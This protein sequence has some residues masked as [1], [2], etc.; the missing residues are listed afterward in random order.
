MKITKLILKNF[1]SIKNAMDSN[2]ISIDF[3]ECKNS[4]CLF[5]GPNA[6]GK[7]SILSQLQPFATLGNLDT[8]NDQPLIL[9]NKEGYKELHIQKKNV[10]YI[11]KH[12][13]SPKNSGGHSVKSYIIKDG[14][15]LNPNGNVTSFKEI[16]KEELGIELDYL[17]LIRLGSNVKSLI[18][19]SD[20]ERKSFMSNILDEIGVYLSYYK[21]VGDKLKNIKEMISHTINKID[22]LG[23]E[24]ISTEKEYITTIENRLESNKIIE[25]DLRDKLSIVNYELSNIDN[26]EELRDIIKKCEKKI[27]KMKT[28]LETEVNLDK[29]DVD[30]YRDEI[31]KKIDKCNKNKNN[32][33]MLK[34]LMGNSINMLD[35]YKNQHHTFSMQYYNELEK[36]KEIDRLEDDLKSTRKKLRDYESALHDYEPK[37]T[38]QELEKFIID[39]KNIQLYLNKTYDFGNKPIRKV[40]SLIKDGKDVNKYINSHIIE[41]DDK[42]SDYDSL[43]LNKLIKM[44]SD[45]GKDIVSSCDKGCDAKRIYNEIVKIC[46][47]HN[48]EDKTKYDPTFYKDMEYSYQSIKYTIEQINKYSDFIKRIP[49]NKIVE[50]FSMNNIFTHIEKLEPIY[51]KEKINSLLSIAKEYDNY[52]MC[53]NKYESD[54]KNLSMFKS[55]SNLDNIKHEI[56][57]LEINI[58]N[59]ENEIKD[60]REQISDLETENKELSRDLE[61]EELILETIV[62][63]DE[64]VNLYSETSSKY[65][66]MKKCNDEIQDIT[67]KLHTIE[68]NIELN[69]STLSKETVKLAQYKELKK[70]LNKYNKIYDEMVFVRSAISSKEGIPLHY[71]FNYLGDAVSITND[72]LYS[73]FEGNSYIDKFEITPT[74]FSIPFYSKGYLLPDVKYASQGELAFLTIALSFALSSKSLKEYNIMLLDEADAAL[75]TKKREMFIKIIE[76]MRE[77]VDGEQTFAITHNEMFSFYPVDIVDLSFS[78]NH[79][80]YQLANY[81]N[82]EKK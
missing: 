81:I 23:I 35:T 10:L 34:L 59:K 80:E 8:R 1:S 61:R 58:S 32:I 19:L 45:S 28:V 2:S 68:K 75:D 63:Y 71:V 66:K 44:V 56:D 67:I 82:I 6:S 12:F 47:D 20:T 72:L 24:D 4:I 22:K 64:T 78:N 76:A 26:K 48:T 25:K 37:Y 3:T 50:E 36:D 53:L 54:S 69:Q 21:E 14:T 52:I 43:L 30:V 38:F 51:D 31:N 5:I 9:D 60:T 79:T 73:V 39:L 16:I 65:E 70:D 11:I 18:G 33:D 55:V 40:I 29:I 15:D 17:K 42:K 74:S 57:N 41:I 77:K 27:S 7:T 46:E 62:S 49:D 13:Y